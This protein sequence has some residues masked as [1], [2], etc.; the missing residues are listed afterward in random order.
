MEETSNA[1]E[2][3]ST[4][5]AVIHGVLGLLLLVAG[6]LFPINWGLQHLAVVKQAAAGARESIVQF[7]QATA[8]PTDGRGHANLQAA[9]LI[10]L[11]ASRLEVPGANELKVKIPNAIRPPAIR[12]FLNQVYRNSVRQQLGNPAIEVKYILKVR[13]IPELQNHEPAI[14]LL[15]RRWRMIS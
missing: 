5:L 9:R 1:D 11:T 6:Y 14:L 12:N 15:S 10:W 7:G 13:Q 8:Q 2:R 3:P 4:G